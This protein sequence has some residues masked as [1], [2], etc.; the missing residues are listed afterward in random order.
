MG[1]L[2]CEN[3]NTKKKRNHQI[4]IIMNQ[5]KKA[6]KFVANI[7]RRLNFNLLIIS[8]PHRYFQ[9]TIREKVQDR[10]DGGVWKLKYDN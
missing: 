1:Y 5:K 6:V 9:E 8:V 7:S 3:L 10:K 4:N 2:P